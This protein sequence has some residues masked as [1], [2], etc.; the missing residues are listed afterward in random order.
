MVCDT[1]NVLPGK[2]PQNWGR[3]WD[4]EKCTCIGYLRQK[5]ISEALPD[6]FIYFT[7]QHFNRFT[8]TPKV[9]VKVRWLQVCR[10]GR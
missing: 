7:I 5:D 9:H 8:K 2:A 6:L 3:V 10:Y 1:F 4:S